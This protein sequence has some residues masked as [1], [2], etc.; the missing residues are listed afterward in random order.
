[1]QETQ[2]KLTIYA[3][4]WT[5][6]CKAN[7]SPPISPL[8]NIR[9]ANYWLDVCLASH[10]KCIHKQNPS[11]PRRVIDVGDVE[12]SRH[13]SLCETTNQHSGRY[14]TLSYC[15]GQEQ[16]I[17]TTLATLSQRKKAIPYATLPKTFKDTIDIA[18]VLGIQYVWIDSLCIIQDSPKDWQQGGSFPFTL[19]PSRNLLI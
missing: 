11:L 7:A 3:D 13:P 5:D 16:G 10:I 2:N 4:V 19:R 15:W 12:T 17:T 14:I 1:M 18:M 9:V 6:I 8:D